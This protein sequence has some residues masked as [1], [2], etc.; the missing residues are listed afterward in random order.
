M[1]ILNRFTCLYN[2]NF[3]KPAL[4]LI[5]GWFFMGN[6]ALGLKSQ[7]FIQFPPG[8]SWKQ[9]FEFISTGNRETQKLTLTNIDSMFDGT[10]YKVLTMES[11]PCNH[12][13]WHS[14][15]NPWGGMFQDTIQ[16]SVVFTRFSM[17]VTHNLIFYDYNLSVGDTFFHPGDA[18][19]GGE[20]KVDSIINV[21]FAGKWRRKWIL[22][23]FSPGFSVHPTRNWFM[24]GIGYGSG[25]TSGPFRE[26]F[27]NT[28]FA[29]SMY[30]ENDTQV[31]A[32]TT[33]CSYTADCLDWVQVGSAQEESE[34]CLEFRQGEKYISFQ[35]GCKGE[36]VSSNDFYYILNLAG[37]IVNTGPV[38][39]KN[40]RI[41]LD[42]WPSGM[43]LFQMMQDEAIV[44]RKKFL[45]Y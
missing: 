7:S 30:C 44:Y 11:G 2:G 17:D 26:Q 14:G 5:A 23:G 21:F 40:C 6:L 33:T 12:H 38:S 32:D 25:L 28:W 36:N 43:Y 34:K 15:P 16:G 42:H 4:V 8:A 1:T 3:A 24:E 10:V 41:D 35:S 20:F 39:E 29:L 37:Q 45:L 13:G 9:E 27:Q 19:G 22:S 31:Y 18:L